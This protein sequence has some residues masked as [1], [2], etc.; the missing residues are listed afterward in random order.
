MTMHDTL[1]SDDKTSSSCQNVR[2]RQQQR[3]FSELSGL[4]RTILPNTVYF[5]TASTDLFR[6]GTPSKDFPGTTYLRNRSVIRFQITLQARQDNEIMQS[7]VKIYLA[8]LDIILKHVVVEIL[9]LPL[10]PSELNSLPLE[11]RRSLRLGCLK[12]PSTFN[13][14]L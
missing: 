4:T 7:V 13:V 6:Q 11:L 14:I 2:Q 1:V 10:P 8:Y 5:S 3:S 9:Q 12:K